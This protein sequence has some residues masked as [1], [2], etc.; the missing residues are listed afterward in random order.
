MEADPG[1]P[2]PTHPDVTPTRPNGAALRQL[3]YRCSITC[4]ER[5]TRVSIIYDVCDPSVSIAWSR[6]HSMAGLVAAGLLQRRPRRSST[7]APFQRIL[8]GVNARLVLYFRPSDHVS[9]ALTELHW[10]ATS[11]LRTPLVSLQVIT[12]SLTSVQR[13]HV[14]RPPMMSNRW[15]RCEQPQMG[16]IIFYR[17]VQCTKTRIGDRAVV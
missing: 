12:R 16:T 8:H 4:H 14:E 9:A 5:R 13:R 7:L 15:P 6:C 2:A 17:P 3:N 11:R 1:D 10:M